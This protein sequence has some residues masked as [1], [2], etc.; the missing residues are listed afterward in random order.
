M[1]KAGLFFTG[2]GPVLML[3]SYD[4]LEN[5][6]LLTKLAAKGIRKFIAYEVSI[7]LLREKYGT[8]YTMVM[9]D[10]KQE[11]DLRVLDYDGHHILNLIALSEL[12]PAV[13]HEG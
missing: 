1:M 5:A 13:L 6:N 7:E 9:N 4:S 12:G 8:H 2:T 10:L 11:D 3:T